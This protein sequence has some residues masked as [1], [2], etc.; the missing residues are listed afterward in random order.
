M[1]KQTRRAF[2]YF[3]NT[4]IVVLFILFWNKLT[5][6][7]VK[8]AGKGTVSFPYNKNKPVSFHDNFIITSEN[9]KFAVFSSHCT[10]LGCKIEKYENGRLV[11]PCHGSEYDLEGNPIKGPAFK[12]LRKIHAELSPDRQT[13]QITG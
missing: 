8:L 3:V 5:S 13:I 6:L 7:H 10:H 12:P 4:G 11:C 9:G 1:A 2:L